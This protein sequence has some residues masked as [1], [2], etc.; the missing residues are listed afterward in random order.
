MTIPQE[1]QPKG[2]TL[3]KATSAD[4]D[5]LHRLFVEVETASMPVALP[6]LIQMLDQQHESRMTTYRQIFPE[7]TDLIIR[8]DGTAIG[9]LM[10][11]L[12]SR[13]IHGVDIA[14][15]PAWQSKG[16]GTAVLQAM[17][18]TAQA[19]GTQVSISAIEGQPAQ[20]LYAKMGFEVTGRTSPH[21]TMLWRGPVA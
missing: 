13:P 10:I 6:A 2:C 19:Y 3:T 15:L 17:S 12:T 9:R 11:D 16:I 14:I 8:K 4:A 1:L 18:K 21:V 20:R 5:F 7:A